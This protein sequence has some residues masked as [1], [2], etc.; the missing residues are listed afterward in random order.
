MN[1]DVRVEAED[2]DITAY[3][4]FDRPGGHRPG[5]EA[6]SAIAADRLL[7]AERGQ[8]GVAGE[9]RGRAGFANGHVR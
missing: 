3:Q 5:L 7:R 8:G 4:L 1:G 6:V 2:F 9:R